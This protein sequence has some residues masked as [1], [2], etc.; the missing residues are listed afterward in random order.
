[1]GFLF[2]EETQTAGKNLT[3]VLLPH[4]LRLIKHHG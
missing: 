4:L 1:M 3:A 2:S